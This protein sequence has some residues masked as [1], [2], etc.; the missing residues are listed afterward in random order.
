MAQAKEKSTT[1]QRRVARALLDQ[2][3]RELD[4]LP[5]I[6]KRSGKRHYW[7]VRPTGDWTADN[8]IGEQHAIDFLQWRAR[9][10]DYSSALQD[11]VK[12]MPRKLTGI[13]VGFLMLI[14]FAA[15][16]GK[17]EAERIVAYWAAMS[18]KRK[19]ARA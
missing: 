7:C 19:A 14:D 18:S 17:H 1:E 9:W 16:A 10:G 12:D 15:V 2:H 3:F 13:E 6:G 5:F 4:E 11:I 8:G